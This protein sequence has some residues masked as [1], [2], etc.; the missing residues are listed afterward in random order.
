M[1]FLV[2]PSVQ[3]EVDFVR[4]VVA[5]VV[6][7]IVIVEVVG[8]IVASTD[9]MIVVALTVV[10]FIPSFKLDIMSLLQIGRASCRE[11]V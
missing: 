8:V 11:R 7:L 3:E 2:V 6:D 10:D 5:S 9:M 1:K 4:V